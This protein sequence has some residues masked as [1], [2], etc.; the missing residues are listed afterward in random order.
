MDTRESHIDKFGR[1]E[2]SRADNDRYGAEWNKENGLPRNTGHLIAR[3]QYVARRVQDKLAKVTPMTDLEVGTFI[4]IPAWKASGCVYAIK[5]ADIGSDGAA[6]VLLQEYPEQNDA[7]MR[8]FR[9]DNTSEYEIA[10]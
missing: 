7:K 1:I 9:L 8:K 4:D 2:V 6:M 5:P 10:E 3:D